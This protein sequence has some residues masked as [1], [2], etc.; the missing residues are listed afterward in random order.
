MTVVITRNI[1][2]DVLERQKSEIKCT[3]SLDINDRIEELVERGRFLAID[4]AVEIALVELIYEIEDETYAR[5]ETRR[6]IMQVADAFRTKTRQD[7]L[8]KRR[9]VEIKCMVSLDI[10]D[11]IEEL[12]EY[13]RFSTINSAVEIALREMVYRIEDETYARGETRC[14]IMQVADAFRAKTRRSILKRARV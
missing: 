3:I 4:D 1:E 7:L 11:Q 8:N 13:G 9:T 2:M 10:K 5:G 12:V 6:D 14:D